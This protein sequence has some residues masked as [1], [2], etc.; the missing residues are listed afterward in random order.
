MN[1]NSILLL[2]SLV[3]PFSYSK[4]I[5]LT[6]DDAPLAGSHIMSGEEKT[7]KIIK[8]LQENNVPDA[9]FFVT[10][11]NITSEFD[12]QRLNDYSD[13]GFHLAHHSHTHVSANKVEVNSYINDFD[14]AHKAL[15]N[16]D[17]VLK[18]HRHP[19]LH[20]G[21]TVNK[22]QSIQAHLISKGYD[23][24][25]V[26][27]DNF[28]WYMN[29]KLLKAKEQGLEVNHDKLG[30]LY[31]DTLWEGIEFYDALAQKHLDRPVKHVLLLHENEIAAL[32]LGKLIK[33]I[34]ANGWEVIAPQDAY[35]DPISD[36]Y[37]AELFQFNKQGRIA[38]LLESKGLEK[39]MLRHKSENI[40]F[41]DKRFE[42]YQVFIK[43]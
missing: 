23:F 21:E 11:A 5:A 1:R 10:T 15:I 13:A 8:H 20:Y 12:K 16:F 36:T 42:E 25:Y 29:S 39:S 35:K 26:T 38:G 31:V 40:E 34:R 3:S 19:Y 27:V 6:F 18:L 33:H 28:D 7:K 24:G 32:F 22:R 4:Q 17:N 9:L 43:Q 30:Q 37:N 2:L 41:L 14:I